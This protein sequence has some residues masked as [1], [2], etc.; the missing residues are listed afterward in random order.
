MN[1]NNDMRNAYLVELYYISTEKNIPMM[2]CD[3]K[4]SANKWIDRKILGG[5]YNGS[6]YYRIREI[7]CNF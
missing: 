3:S 4:E 6:A 1:R 2:V 5:F 7:E